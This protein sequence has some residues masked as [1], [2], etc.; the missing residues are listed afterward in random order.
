M[1]L[2]GGAG[3]DVLKGGN[4]DDILYGFGGNDTLTGAGGHDVLAGHEGAD[5]LSGGVG[6]DYMLGGVGNDTID[7]GAGIDWAAYEDATSAVTVDLNLTTTQNTLGAGSD[8]ITGV[9]NLYGSAFNDILTGNT[10]VNFLHGGA[11]HDTIYGGAGDDHIEGGAGYDV[12][13]GGAGIDTVS[14]DDLAQGVG[15]FMNSTLGSSQRLGVDVDQLYDVENVYGT[16]F[17]DTL[18]GG[19]NDNY[20]M[21]REGDD[22]LIQGI[23]ASH[24]NGV[25]V[26]D[27]G[28]G[29]DTFRLM[30]GDV[31]M[32][33]GEGVDTLDLGGAYFQNP[34]IVLDLASEDRQVM[35]QFF[36]IKLSSVENIVINNINVAAS[37]AENQFTVS[38]QFNRVIFR[39]LEEVGLGAGADRIVPDWTSG[40]HFTVDLTAIDANVTLAGDQA[41]KY[42]TSFT[43]QA[44]EVTFTV[45]MAAR[46]TLFQFDVNGD[47]VSDA[48]LWIS[49]VYGGM[50]GD[51]LL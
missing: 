16:I 1:L 41:F 32:L 38:G 15:V 13:Y 51:F 39:S 46:E 22:L 24:G 35:D 11:G 29:N 49:G 34:A 17:N 3:R 8:K 12:I 2:R 48:D 37:D 40:T 23:V 26:L 18:Q 33:G 6:D 43:H 4:A 44:G 20:L 27:G 14:F 50:P 31:T 10:G 5:S 30:K 19:T 45:D 7:G 36:Q 28:A 25:D 47:A 42:V 21:G 9:E